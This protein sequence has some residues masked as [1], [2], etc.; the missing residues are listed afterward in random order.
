MGFCFRTPEL[1]SIALVVMRSILGTTGNCN[2]TFRTSTCEI[3]DNVSVTSEFFSAVVRNRSAHSCVHLSDFVSGS[4]SLPAPPEFTIPTI[5]PLD[6]V[7]TFLREGKS[8]PSA[9]Y[10]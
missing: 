8:Y 3:I 7:L 5:L 10:S 4:K 6:M 2:F 1:E 9:I